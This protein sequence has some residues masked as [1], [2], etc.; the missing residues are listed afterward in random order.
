MNA[1]NVTSID[2]ISLHAVV[3]SCSMRTAAGPTARKGYLQ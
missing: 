2:L 3:H 1:K